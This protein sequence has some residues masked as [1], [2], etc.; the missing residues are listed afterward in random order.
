MTDV[1]GERAYELRPS[2]PGALVVLI[3]AVWVGAIA[4]LVNVD[5]ADKYL[6]IPVLF[7]LFG[8]FSSILPLAI[9]PNVA[10]VTNGSILILFIVS[11]AVLPKAPATIALIKHL[12]R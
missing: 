7:A 1:A 2:M 6:W 3:L 4:V 10:V 9:A 5:R 12:A 11:L 8:I